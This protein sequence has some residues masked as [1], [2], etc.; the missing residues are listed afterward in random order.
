MFYI[1]KWSN[2]VHFIFLSEVTLNLGM[3]PMSM[4]YMALPR[5]T[6]VT[7]MAEK[8]IFLYMSTMPKIIY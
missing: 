2:K 3:P 5:L 4:P 8:K 1:K 7:D 6:E